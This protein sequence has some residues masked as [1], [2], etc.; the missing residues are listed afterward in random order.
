MEGS[1]ADYEGSWSCIERRA[2]TEAV[3]LIK[4]APDLSQALGKE[5]WEKHGKKKHREARKTRKKKEEKP[6]KQKNA[7]ESL[8]SPLDTA[9][10]GLL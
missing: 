3:A 5:G 8:P 9:S 2:Q 7:K 10:A 1:M 6:E 4:T